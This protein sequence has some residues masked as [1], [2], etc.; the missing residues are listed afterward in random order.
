LDSSRSV[1]T[2]VADD[3]DEPKI[4]WNQQD[5]VDEKCTNLL[6]FAVEEKQQLEQPP[7]VEEQ[8]S[9]V[10]EGPL[11]PEQPEEPKISLKRR[12]VKRPRRL[13][14]LT[15]T[16]N[17]KSY[18]KSSQSKDDDKNKQAIATGEVVLESRSPHD[19]DDDDDDEQV[20]FE[21][22]DQSNTS[23]FEDE[24][25]DQLSR[26]YSH[27]ADDSL[28]DKESSYQ[29]LT[30]RVLIS[31]SNHELWDTAKEDERYGEWQDAYQGAKTAMGI[32]SIAGNN[33]SFFEEFP[34]IS[35]QERVVVFPASTRDEPVI[36]ARPTFGNSDEREGIEEHSVRISHEESRN[37]FQ[38]ISTGEQR[39]AISPEKGI[40][41]NG[42]E[43]WVQHQ[44]SK[45]S[46]VSAITTTDASHES[47]SMS[48][49]SETLKPVLRDLLRI[50]L[51]A[52]SALVIQ[53]W[54]RSKQARQKMLRCAQERTRPNDAAR[55]RRDLLSPKVALV[56]STR[57]FQSADRYRK[58][59]IVIQ[60][61][62]RSWGCRRDFL[63]LR[64]TVIKAQ[65]YSRRFLQWRRQHYA[66]L[67]ARRAWL[68]R[69]NASAEW[70]F[71]ATGISALS[72]DNSYLEDVPVNLP[73]YPISVTCDMNDPVSALSPLPPAASLPTRLPSPLRTRPNLQLLTTVSQPALQLPPLSPSAKNR[74]LS[75]DWTTRPSRPSRVRSGLDII[76]YKLKKKGP[77]N[78]N[79]EPP[80]VFFPPDTST[81]EDTGITTQPTSKTKTKSTLSFNSPGRTTRYKCSPLASV[82]ADAPNGADILKQRYSEK[83]KVLST[84]TQKLSLKGKSWLRGKGGA[85]NE[86][87]N[88]DSMKAEPL[89]VR[90]E[91][92]SPHF[93]HFP[94]IFKP[95]YRDIH[96]TACTSIQAIWR[97]YRSQLAFLAL[98]VK[99]S[100]VVCECKNCGTLSQ[101][102]RVRQK[103]QV[104]CAAKAINQV[105]CE[106]AK[107]RL[108]F[109]EAE[110]AAEWE[111]IV[112]FNFELPDG[113]TV[114]TFSTIYVMSTI[115]RTMIMERMTKKRVFMLIIKSALMQHLSEQY[116]K[117]SRTSML[118]RSLTRRRAPLER[119]AAVMIEKCAR[120]SNHR[121]RYT[122]KKKAVLFIQ[123]VTRTWLAE[124]LLRRA[125]KSSTKIEAFFR[126]ELVRGIVFQYWGAAIALRPYWN[127]YRLEKMATA[128]AL[129]TRIQ[130]LFRGTRARELVAQQSIFARIIQKKIRSFIAREKFM[131]KK[132][133]YCFI[134]EWWRFWRY[135][136]I[137]RGLCATIIQTSYRSYR[138]SCDF[139]SLCSATIAI[140]R[141]VRGHAVRSA[142]RSRNKAA[143]LIQRTIRAILVRRRMNKSSTKI[144][145]LY[146]GFSTESKYQQLL[147]SILVLQSQAR[148]MAC[149]RRKKKREREIKA[150]S[151]IQAFWRGH[152]A[153]LDFLFLRYVF[154]CRCLIYET[155]VDASRP[156][157]PVSNSNFVTLID[158]LWNN[159]SY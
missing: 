135:D 58:S 43:M 36:D 16:R 74:R 17:W 71:D 105:G 73:R 24:Q 44:N 63:E 1:L 12:G 67:E 104:R 152:C 25:N 30:E 48:Q 156:T 100:T 150:A 82:V 101:D 47:D 111:N 90:P 117:V 123:K 148:K 97:K 107:E 23:T 96:F 5:M 143:V 139:H 66:V 154:C 13:K 110:V 91:S 79:R 37:G 125:L 145:A 133:A 4:R 46:F 137:L 83:K 149:E 49:H 76:K 72:F 65:R 70:S 80:K 94:M 136:R 18:S 87:K 155:G 134:Q 93:E 35:Q 131:R 50:R 124:R 146:R 59:V 78:N 20:V 88:T 42:A 54:V 9:L 33:N 52:V 29:D 98:I 53:R 132:R 118:E 57:K 21:S 158:F 8:S 153:R 114:R 77:A 61:A 116:Q 34:L 45:L 122:L 138:D 2:T 15:G 89:S 84:P 102:R 112:H 22:S 19:N 119:D 40:N 27:L 129:V 11:E 39:E 115:Q 68:N 64:D 130:A 62:Y 60:A 108:T 128:D 140:Q 38:P 31:M 147:W 95:I 109:G 120:G 99:S 92:S 26:R 56:R 51:C 106:G 141:S 69:G 142:L 113:R 55:R 14:A 86:C 126:G 28:R 103:A 121:R 81:L 127:E 159:F 32:G 10:E 151:Q 3:D 85:A 7:V 6:G 41:D 144:Q 75:T 157:H